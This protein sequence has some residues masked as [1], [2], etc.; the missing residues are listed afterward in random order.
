MISQQQTQKQQLKILPQQIQLLNLYFLNTLE[1]EQRIKNE[2]EENP[3]L[4]QQEKDEFDDA[5]SATTAES[6]DFQ[7]YDEYMYDDVPDYKAEYQNY[8]NTEDAPNIAIKSTTHFKDEAK[9]QLR[10]LDIDEK[11]REMAEYV[12]DLLNNQGL[13]D[14]PLEEVADDLSFQFQ[15]IVEV[16]AVEEALA[17]IQTLEPI[18]IGSCSVKD[19]LLVQ[20]KAMSQKRPDV[21][22]AIKL[23]QNHYNDLM[24]R[25][26]E[27]IHHAL[28]I[29]EEELRVVLNLIGSLKF[30][31]VSENAS[32]YEPKN[33]IIPDYIISRY[34]DSIQVSLYSSKSGSVFVNQVLYD[35]LA[36]QV[37]GKNKSANQ[38]VKSKLQS[39]QWFVNAVK[40]REDTMMRIMQ[41]IVQIQNEY[42]MEGDIRLLK[43]MVLRNIA[44]LTGLDISTVSRITSNKYADSH[45]GLIYLKDLFSEGIADKK[46]EVISNK[47]IQSVIEEAIA[48]EDKQHPY[49]DQQLV[50]ILSAK[51]YNIARRT[52][53][54]YREHMHI[55]IAQIR[56]VWA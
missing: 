18:G 48:N 7:D 25:Q 43:P 8:F 44:D 10:L 22:C 21:K 3:F 26:F 53:A 40:Q 39:A 23:M 16:D 13:M 9:Q 32:D 6:K 1:L 47:V 35:Q 20:L 17:V 31:P 55:P 19:C 24:H 2:L 14:R 34:G 50:T 11:K 30:Y 45:F 52:V 28:N 4:D 29:D 37:N 36:Q 54:K 41:C 56:A 5:N 49:T 12:I 51:G 15:S 33:T 46:G 27:K 42:F 38:Y